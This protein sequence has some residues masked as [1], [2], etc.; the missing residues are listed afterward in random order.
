[1]LHDPM[2]VS[3]QQGEQIADEIGAFCYRECSV[4]KRLGVYT[5]FDDLARAALAVRHCDK[6]DHRC[7]MC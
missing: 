1:M 7:V 5:V 2:Y 6:G 4:Y 3:P